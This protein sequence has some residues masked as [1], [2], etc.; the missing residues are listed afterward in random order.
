MGISN[1]TVISNNKL[2]VIIRKLF[3]PNERLER[4]EKTVITFIVMTIVVAVGIF[5]SVAHAVSNVSVVFD[6]KDAAVSGTATLSS[7]T[8]ASTGKYVSFGA[9]AVTSAPTPTP[10]APAPTPS[11]P[12]APVVTSTP[13]G[14]NTGV[15]VGTKLTVHNGDLN[16]TTAGTVIDSKDIRGLVKINAANITIKNSIIRGR[17]MNGSGALINNLGGYANLIVTDTELFPTVMSPYANGFYGYNLTATRLNIHNVIDGIHVTGSNVTVLNSWIHDHAHYDQDPTQGGAPSH[18]DGIQIQKG[19]NI[20]V[21]GN[22]L[23]DS[24]SA[25]VQITQ[26]TGKVSNFRYTNNYADGGHCTVNIA[27]KTYGPLLGTVIKDNKFGR[28]TSIT[29][30][31]IIS[32]TTTVIDAARNYFTDGTVAAVR[33][34]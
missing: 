34:G 21:T 27:Q 12:P 18:D 29:N 26:D 23:T 25:A 1:M 7:N 4:E 14:S 3:S 17:T 5:V 31:A 19:D 22:R 33:R 2:A 30:C 28:S 13:S 10:T 15:P 9:T 8:T 24:Y 16:I 32:K 6:L 11:A 20:T